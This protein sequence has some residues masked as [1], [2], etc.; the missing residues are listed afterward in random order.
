MNE[1]IGGA[2][3]E[4]AR[5][6]APA[7][8]ADRNHAEA[9]ALSVFSDALGDGTLQRD[10]WKRGI[11]QFFRGFREEGFSR[12]HGFFLELARVEGHF[13]GNEERCDDGAQRHVFGEFEGFPRAV[14]G[15]FGAVNRAEDLHDPPE[16][17]IDWA[18]V[19]GSRVDRQLL[20]W[21]E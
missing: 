15:R 20:L 19:F 14:Q 12:L 3:E 21:R 8:A 2:A 6:S 16:H 7:F 17:C 11:P 1:A 13:G 9:A 10:A 5:D 18:V 4:D